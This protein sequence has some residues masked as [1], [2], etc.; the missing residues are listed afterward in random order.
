MQNKKINIDM[1]KAIPLKCE[2]CGSDNFKKNYK[3]KEIPR[4]LVGMPNDLHM[5]GYIIVCADCA[6]PINKKLNMP[7]N[8][9]SI[10]LQVTPTKQNT[11]DD[12]TPGQ[13]AQADKKITNKQEK[14]K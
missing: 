8:M 4:L 3:I 11:E 9:S 13:E 1:S 7:A 10:Q 2:V 14:S 5:L 12:G 6:E